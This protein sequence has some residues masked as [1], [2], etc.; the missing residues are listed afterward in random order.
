M[1][2]RDIRRLFVPVFVQQPKTILAM[3]HP[4]ISD[5]YDSFC[6][7][8][9][10]DLD[11]KNCCGRCSVDRGNVAGMR[12]ENVLIFFSNSCGFC[13]NDDDD[14]ENDVHRPTMMAE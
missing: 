4:K 2:Y 9:L 3:F 5:M 10:L 12:A 11:R 1:K 14:L 6:R 8:V 7:K 13:S